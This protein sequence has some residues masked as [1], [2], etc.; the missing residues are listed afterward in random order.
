MYNKDLMVAVPNCTNNII[1]LNYKYVYY[2]TESHYDSNSKHTKDDRV[3]IGKLV[4]KDDK[5][6]MYPNEKYYK[7]FGTN[8]EEKER[9]VEPGKKDTYLHFGA[10]IA[11]TEAFSHYGAME[12]LKYSFPKTYDKIIALALC[13]I[14]SENSTAQHYD[15]WSFSNYSGID[16]SLSSGQISE[17]YKNIK[18][19]DIDAFLEFYHKKYKETFPQI[20]KSAIAYDSTNQNTTSDNFYAEFGHAKEDKNIPIINTLMLVDETTSIPLYYEHFYGSLLDKTQDIYSNKMIKHLGFQK[21]FFMLDR[22]YF[23]NNSLKSLSQYTFGIMCPDN[24]DFVKD[25]INKYKNEIRFKEKYFISEENVYCIEDTV[26]YNGST[27][28]AYV[29]YDLIRAID[30]VNAIHSKLSYMESKIIKTKY[31]NKKLDSVYGKY[32]EFTKL[33]KTGR[34]KFNFKQKEDVVQKEIDDAGMFIV[35]SNAVK[36]PKEMILIARA[37]DK[38]EKCFRRLKSGLDLTTTYTHNMDTY[39]GK[40]FIAFVALITCETYRYLIRDILNK[41]SSETT[42]TTLAEL[43]KLIIY[44]DKNG[45]YVQRYALTKK[46]KEILNIFGITQEK[47]TKIINQI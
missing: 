14:D 39:V 27:Y 22:G 45:K 28:N 21:L 25:L 1:I 34:S 32:F 42:F 38:G 19:K 44:V 15:K 20:N 37:R 4:D 24:V 41:K 10:Y 2:F 6:K 5:T 12:A 46:E 13:S 26:T 17:L 16:Y 31:Y 18:Q 8:K 47:L 35:L 40:M 11:L 29:Y 30:E 33:S 43:Y 9:L 7:I 3:S 36:T 23:S